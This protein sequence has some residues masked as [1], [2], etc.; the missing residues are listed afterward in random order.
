MRLLILLFFAT[1]LQ[2]QSVLPLWQTISAGAWGMDAGVSRADLPDNFQ[3]YLLDKDG[4][5]QHLGKAT[6]EFAGGPALPVDLPLADGR[7][8]RFLVWESPIVAP[9]FSRH[10]PA[11]RTYAGKASDGSGRTVRMGVGYDGFHAYVLGIDQQE[12][13]ITNQFSADKM[14]YIVY[15]NNTLPVASYLPRGAF[16]CGVLEAGIATETHKSGVSVEDRGAAP[17]KLRKYRMAIAAKAEY[18]LY[19]SPAKDTSVVQSKIV[20]A[21]NYIV[22]LMERDFGVRYELIARNKDLTF[23]DPDADP[24]SG[25]ETGNW[26]GQNQA[27]V[28]GIIGSANYDIGHVFAVYVSGSAIGIAGGR[29]CSN[30]GKARGCS[31]AN[32]PQGT[33]FN[34]VTAHEM[35][36]QMS[37]SHTMNNC[38]DDSNGQLAPGNAYEPGS[39]ST[40]MGYPGACGPNDIQGNNDPYYHISNIDQINFYVYQDDGNTCGITENSNNTP[41]EA[42]ILAVNDTY[43]PI[44]TPFRLTGVA[45]DAENDVLSYCWEQFNLGPTAPLGSPITTSPSFRSF[46]PV[47]T[48]TRFFPRLN[49][50]ANNV[51]DKDEVLPTYNRDLTFRFTVRDNHPGVGGVAS[52]V[53]NLK[54]TVNAGPFLVLSPNSSGTVWQAGSLKEIVWDVAKTDIAPVNCKS[55]DILFSTDAGLTFPVVLAAGVPNNGRHCILVPE[56]ATTKGRLM[57]AAKDN[58]FFD[59]SNTNL[60]IESNATAGYGLCSPALKSSVCLPGAYTGTITTTSL[61]G[62]NTPVAL[63]ASG[64][65]AGAIATFSPNPVVPG[66]DAALTIDFPA[67]L[68]EGL[69]NISVSG[70]A[71]G[72]VQS[73]LLNLTAVRNDFSAF[74]LEYPQDGAT[75]VDLGPVY[76]WQAVADANGYDIQI[77]SNPSFDAGTLLVNRN[78]LSVDTLKMP[79]ILAEGQTV[80]WRVRPVNE[81]GAGSWSP[82]F[83]FTTKV[84]SCSTFGALD[85]PKVISGNSTPTVESKILVPANATISDVNILS[86]AGNHNF[87]KDLDVRLISPAGTEVLLWTNKCPGTYNFNLGFDDSASSVFN[88]PPPNTGAKYKAVGLLSAFNGQNASGTW[89]LRVKDLVIGSG[90]SLSGFQLELCSSQAL[91]APFGVNNSLLTLPSGT[92]AAIT[93]D[94]LRVDDTNN[95]PD[96]LVYTLVTLPGFG[97]LK[98]DE[99]V[100]SVGDTFTQADIN[101]G[102]LRFFDYGN[103][104][105]TDNFRFTVVDGAGGMLTDIFTIQPLT[106]GTEEAGRH[107]AFSLSPNPTAG[108]VIL[109][110]AEPAGDS[111][112]AILYDVSGRMIRR[113]DLSAGG[114]NGVFS[115]EH[116]PEG[117]YVMVVNDGTGLGISKLVIR[118]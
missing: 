3:T 64:L 90:G 100:L 81:C 67:D 76:A 69:Y 53:V 36:H 82:V 52:P 50:L 117:V 2:A 11:I 87:F 10:F 49:D 115:L 88:C 70:N 60:T 86:V 40:I 84:Q 21:L 74:A 92:N 35:C 112:A 33:Y 55:V 24:Y 28:S 91:S 105:G 116:I 61:S 110:L 12:Q 103:N 41:P 7:L 1:S 19:H 106:T 102:L 97:L 54:S 57:V 47:S 26:M 65:P 73:I 111:A 75:G 77:A 34:L 5:V 14:Q 99:V 89:T 18:S 98:R 51:V 108:Q 25:T 113:W 38:S 16:A 63:A 107:L 58:V 30:V 56:L 66:T 93:S 109:Q 101:S 32:P 13:T 45:T 114:M 8:L 43:I 29:V 96:Q 17:V 42:A 78:N 83:V 118:R 95:T 59:I 23:F 68:P 20:A 104:S 72:N 80:Y 37:G 85:L 71:G 31:S 9:G 48:P 79:F 39:G 27:V 4:L 62:F 44:A 46:N 6:M 15:Q 22:A 94:L